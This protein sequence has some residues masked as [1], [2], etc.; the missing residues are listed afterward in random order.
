MEDESLVYLR[1][2]SVDECLNEFLN[3][4]S[5]SDICA[6]ELLLNTVAVNLTVYQQ[7]ELFG[8]IMYYIEGDYLTRGNVEENWSEDM[9]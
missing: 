9:Y 5:K 3:E 1:G 2:E 4:Y 6:A 7:T 8:K